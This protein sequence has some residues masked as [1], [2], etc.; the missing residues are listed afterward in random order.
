MT[1]IWFDLGY[2]LARL[3]R[4]EVFQQHLGQLGIDRSI[5]SIQRAYHLAD[6]TFMREY[7]GVL[8]HM[9][10]EAKQ[11]YNTLLHEH[12]EVDVL[13]GQLHLFPGKGLKQIEWHAFPETISVLRQLKEKGFGIGLISNWNETADHVL[14]QTGIQ[15][16]LDYQVISSH[17]Q[18]EKPDER[19]FQYALDQAHVS[20]ADCL[21]VGDNYYDDVIGSRKV[22]MDS[23]LINPFG[24]LGIEEL[25]DVH[26]ISGVGE[27]LD[28]LENRTYNSLKRD[29]TFE[30]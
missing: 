3:N 23:I 12:L 7:P 18:I 29:V 25:Q 5:L 30:N 11:L 20:A 14:K 13:P 27:L 4:E 28:V 15:P 2:T 6:K 17:I 21:Y 1:F 16:Y 9:D 19:I 26:T 10:A 24:K 8:G 22:G